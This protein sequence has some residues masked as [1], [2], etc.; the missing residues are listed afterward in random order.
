MNYFE[1]DISVNPKVPWADI[2]AAELAELGCDSFEPTEN[3]VKAYGPKTHIQLLEIEAC[4]ASYANNHTDI[5]IQFSINEIQSQNWNALWEAD[6]EPVFVE[7]KLAILAPFHPQ[8]LA[9]P[10]TL[11]I[12]PQMSF[13]TGHHQTTWMMAKSILE[14]TPLPKNIL[15]MGS[16]TGVLAILAEKLGGK[17][18]DAIDIEEG[19]FAN[20]IE[21]CE[22]NKCRAVQAILGGIEQ[23]GNKKYAMI[24]ANINKNVLLNQIPRYAEVLTTNGILLLSGFFESDINDLVSLAT[25]H[26]VHYDSHLTKDN[27][28]CI[29]LIKN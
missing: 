18:I 29:K 14:S 10:I 21:N 9:K 16:G 12:Q 22:R 24:F 8:H 13:G 7:D 25:K 23:I 11:W 5:N 2:L 19:A 1:F 27:W 17:N 3:G 26:S 20:S 6:F 15:D 28:A 4:L